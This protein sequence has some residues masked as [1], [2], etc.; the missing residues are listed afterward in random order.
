[1]LISSK[2][3]HTIHSIISSVA[4]RWGKDTV[5]LECTDQFLP[6][7]YLS[8]FTANRYGLLI[9]DNG[10]S[11]VHTPAYLLADN[12]QLRKI[13]ADLD[14]EGNLKFES[15]TSYKALCQADVESTIHRLSREEQLNKLKSEFSLPTYDVLS[16]DYKEDYSRRIPVINESLKIAV[17]NYAQ[18]S[19][20]RIFINPDILTRYTEKLPAEKNRRFVI[21]LKD[22]NHYIDSVQISVPAGY[23]TESK[24]RDME[25]K[26]NSKVFKPD[27][28][29]RK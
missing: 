27:D 16:F 3:L 23:E 18:V 11:L 17:N 24:P 19:G 12:V 1:M 4:C 29:F 8:E 22:E 14:N 26:T 13:S 20:K 25:L 2:I 10:G 9:D 28:P 7:G 5:W 6:P 21:D 15:K